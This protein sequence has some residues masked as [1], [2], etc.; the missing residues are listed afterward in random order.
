MGRIDLPKHFWDK[1]EFEPTSGCWLWNGYLNQ[2]GYG[3][4]SIN[5]RLQM[6][7]RATYGEVPP[8]TEIDHKCRV[9][10][11]CNPDHLEAVPHAENVRRGLVSQANSLR[12]LD[13]THC[14]NGH[15]FT[16]ENT[17]YAKDGG[18]RCKACHANTERARRARLKQG[19][20]RG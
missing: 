7:H 15:A 14:K 13:R 16:D 3:R 4:V 11:C 12:K 19:V 20:E 1:V 9:R 10:S 17:A 2:D 5:K 18:R 8:G 6:V